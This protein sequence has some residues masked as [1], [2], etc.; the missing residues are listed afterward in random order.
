[1]D[2]ELVAVESLA[3]HRA[4]TAAP[5]LHKDEALAPPLQ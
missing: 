5:K 3:Y 2:I 4:D 1:M